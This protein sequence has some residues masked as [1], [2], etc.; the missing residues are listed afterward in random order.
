M[1][2]IG[3]TYLIEVEKPKDEFVGGIYLPQTASMNELVH[4]I[5]K[6]IE[7]GIGFSEDEK[8]DLIPLETKV[9]LDYRKEVAQNKIRLNFGEH[10]YYIY[11]PEHILAIIEEAEE[12]D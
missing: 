2:P 5:G 3:K 11:E 10:T 7:Y 12:N 4:Y 9:L 6:V 8:K 1:K